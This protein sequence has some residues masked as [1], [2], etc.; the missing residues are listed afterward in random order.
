MKPLNSILATGLALTLALALAPRVDA[1]SFTI[2]S[3]STTAQTLSASQT[4]TVSSAGSLSVNGS[5]VAVTITGNNATLTNSGTMNQTGTGR[6]IRDNTGVTGLVV[7]NNANAL[8]QTADADVIQMNKSSASVTFNNYGTLT[9]LNASKGG[10]QAIDFSAILSGSNIVN[11]Y[12]GGVIQARDADA[13]RPG[14]NGAINNYGTILATT[15]TDTSSD[16]IDAQANTGVVISNYSTGSITG[17]RHGITGGIASGTNSSG[18][19]AYT[20]T[21]TNQAGGTI[22]GN[23]GSGI[24]IDGYSASEVVTINN[25]GTITGNGSTGDG[26]G[27]DVD[28]V[29]HITNSGV[30]RSLNSYS[31]TG[32]AQSEGIT[33]GGGS[34]VNTGTIS[35]EV[36]S[37]NTTAVG[38]GITFAGVDT[39][40]TA[41]PIYAASSVEN[42]GLIKGQNDSA[43]AV[44]GGASGFTV[45]V[46]NHAGGVIEGGGTSA[47]IRTGADND[48]INNA[49]T[50]RANGTG[51]A[52]DMGAGN[53][54]LN[55]TGGSASV[56]GD[57]SGGTGGTNTLSITPGAGNKF[58]YS[59]AISNFSSVQINVGTVTFSGSST[60]AGNTTIASGGK[61][62][63]S[64]TAGSATGSGTVNIQNGGTLTGAGAVGGDVSLEAGGT[65]A[66]GD[67][68]GTLAIGG[69]LVIAGGS[70]LAFEL[71]S[72]LATS[73]LLAVSGGLTYEGS[74]LI[75]LSLSGTTAA[76]TYTLITFASS[77]LTASDFQVEAADGT[78]ATVIVSDTSVT[79]QV[80]PEPSTWAILALG[81]FVALGWARLRQRCEIAA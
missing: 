75:T 67:G 15:T 74:G 26:D 3:A 23:N 28:G 21:V 8:M 45:T 32:T 48:T 50:I 46:T 16:G 34:I 55:I 81:G 78:E 51:K 80:V 63:V 71:G 76:G 27:I 47:A 69:D 66:A 39:T 29:V 79:V 13:V 20:M 10:A 36:A 6:L 17:A 1:S 37:G 38:R 4:G 30:I 12:A 68:G 18:S 42:S 56:I 35:G 64:N 14:V 19:S 53:N 24:N 5:T 7:T 52:I 44:D 9:S 58:S 57:I 59:G 11:N 49:G 73:D 33:V 25:A 31:A 65:I 62:V 61:L 72:D 22:T 2:S 54:T 77:N 43:I 60:Y 70:T 41:E 40:G